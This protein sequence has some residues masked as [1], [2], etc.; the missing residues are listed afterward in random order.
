AWAI[1]G[2]LIVVMS[3]ILSLANANRE[4]RQPLFRNRL[5]Y[6]WLVVFFTLLGDIILFS[7]VVLIGQPLRLAAVITAA[8]V[9]GTHYVPDL[10][11]ITRRGL[12]YVA[13]VIVIVSFY[14]AGFLLLQAVFG[15]N[16]DFNPLLAGAGVALL[17]A[18]IFAPLTSLVSR[19]ITKWMRGDQYDASLTI[20]QY[21]ESISNILDMDRLANI[22][23]G[24]MLEAMQID[25]GFLFLVDSDREA[26][27]R[28]IYKL[29]SAR[30]PEERQMVVM[31]L[32]ENGPVASYFI[33]DQKPLLQYDL[34]LLPAFR[35]SSSAE[36]DW[37]AQ[38]HT[39]VYIPIF[40]KRQWI[41]LLAFGSKLSGN[42]FSREDL[43]VLSAHANQTAV[44]LENARLVDNLMRLNQE[45]RVARRTLEK[46]NQELERIDQAKSDFISIA[47]HELRTPLTVIKGYTEMLMDDPK[48]DKNLKSM[49]K[50]IHDGTMRLHEVMDSMFDI[51]QIDARS[52]KPHL[53]LV[54]M[55]HLIKEVSMD[56]AKSIKERDLR[57][58]IHIPTIP[59]VKADPHL[60]RKLLHHLVR[61]AVKFTPDH[62]KIHISGKYIPAIIN[63]PN[64]GVEIVISDTGVG[65]DPNLREVIFTKFYQPGE[66]GKHSTSKTRFKGGGAGLGLALSKGIV[67]AHGGRIWVE[68]AGYDEVN[69]PGSQ[70]HVILPLPKLE[71]GE[72]KRESETL[73]FEI[74][75]EVG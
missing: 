74:A 75:K 41:G 50:G 23:V 8:Y 70:F 31:E 18:I 46:N 4:S 2:W 55:G 12:I 69:F 45:L 68:S 47:S 40:A 36:R 43:S 22:A 65:V 60:L 48:L 54:D 30:S 6:W 16:Q 9:V 32:D 33:R 10:K 59:L 51:A 44:A 42:R 21:S 27:G 3:F 53:Q 34:D 25:R 73:T 20:H 1:L 38:L 39:E 57:L 49:M 29:R 58:N 7:G 64:G 63:L 24:I 62:G 66:L 17:I 56:H 28:R 35:A 52:L 11:N 5:N 37:F 15:K 26:D 67:E 72:S 13:S 19:T 61:N 71:T 14:V